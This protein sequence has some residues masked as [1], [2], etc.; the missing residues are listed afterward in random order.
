M[1]AISCVSR[2]WTTVSEI[3]SVVF[4]DFE[5]DKRKGARGSTKDFF[6]PAAL[7]QSSSGC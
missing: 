7:T 3:H 6:Q 4:H 2:E 5:L 1:R